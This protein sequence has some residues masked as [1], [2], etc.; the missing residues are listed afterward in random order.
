MVAKKKA[1]H[2][3]EEDHDELCWRLCPMTKMNLNLRKKD[4][5]IGDEFDV[6]PVDTCTQEPTDKMETVTWCAVAV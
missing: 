3:E 1:A 2:M 5:E 4:F 6:E